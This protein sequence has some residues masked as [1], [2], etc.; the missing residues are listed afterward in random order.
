MDIYPLNEKVR[1]F[2]GEL[3]GKKINYEFYKNVNYI[4]GMNGSGKTSL[5]HALIKKYGIQGMLLM[6][7]YYNKDCEYISLLNERLQSSRLYYEY[8]LTDRRYHLKSTYTNKKLAST[9]L[10][11]GERN[12]LR[13]MCFVIK[14]KGEFECVLIDDI[15]EKLCTD[16]VRCIVNDFQTIDPDLQIIC[17]THSPQ[18]IQPHRDKMINITKILGE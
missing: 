12:Y 11:A 6:I 2:K 5:L 15:E 8:E 9:N 3:F 7:E 1:L 4:Y 14:N 10:T 17:T 13:L 18:I 16:W